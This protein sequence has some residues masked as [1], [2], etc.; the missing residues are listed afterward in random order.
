MPTLRKMEKKR[1]ETVLKRR[2]CQAAILLWAAG[3]PLAYAAE[4]ANDGDVFRAV[5][6]GG[7]VHDSNLFRLP[8]FV[9]PQA[10]LGQSTKSDTVTN[11][12]VGLR[13]DKPYS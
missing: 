10:A 9:D 4:A 13:V 6:G 7:T 5:V 3:C 2:F 12:Y 8:D 11:A 1:A